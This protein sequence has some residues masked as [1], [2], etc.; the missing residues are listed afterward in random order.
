MT[1]RTGLWL[2]AFTSHRWSKSEAT[3][4]SLR[5]IEL[6]ARPRRSRSL[7]PGDQVGAGDLAHLLGP[8]D[9]CKGRELL[10]V[11]AVSAPGAR[12]IEGEQTTPVPGASRP[13]PGIRRGSSA[14]PRLP[15]QS[16]WIPRFAGSH[17]RGIGLGRDDVLTG[18]GADVSQVSSSATGRS[19]SVTKPLHYRGSSA[20][21]GSRV[22]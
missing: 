17:G 20:P 10:H 11:I 7:K 18:Q 21:I 16:P 3:A 1:P 6:G 8:F 5:R 4:A 14:C 9:P 22:N 15:R 13:S 12:V 19:P 2:T